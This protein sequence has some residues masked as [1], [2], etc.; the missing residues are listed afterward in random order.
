MT[1]KYELLHTEQAWTLISLETTEPCT[2][3]LVK[4]NRAR[5]EVKDPIVQSRRKALKYLFEFLID[6]W[7]Y[8]LDLYVANNLY[9]RELGSP[10]KKSGDCRY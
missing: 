7:P 2:V 3:R 1:Q 5:V 9:W 10:E 6:F 8:L 4:L